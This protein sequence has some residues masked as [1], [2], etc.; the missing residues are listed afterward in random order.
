MSRL[1]LAS[2]L[3]LGSCTAIRPLDAP[4]DGGGR[5]GSP[6]TR[7]A[8]ADGGTDAGADAC[9]ALDLCDG[10]DDDCEPSTADGSGDPLVGVPCDGPDADSCTEG[11]SSCED[12]DVVCSDATGDTLE[13]CGGGDEDCDGETDEPG[14]ANGLTFYPDMDGDGNG[15]AAMGMTFCA[16]PGAPWLILGGD[17]DD[18]DPQVRPGRAE[19]CNAIDDD[20]DGRVDDG[21]GCSFNCDR[22][23][24]AGHTYQICQQNRT[25][26][27]ARMA[28]ESIGYHLVI[29]EDVT[30]N[31]FLATETQGMF[32]F[33]GVWIGLHDEG[34]GF[35]WVDG[36]T[37]AFTAWDTGEPNGT[38]PCA[39]MRSSLAEGRWADL[40]CGVTTGFVCETP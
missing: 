8:A 15:D 2:L 16:F 21:A 22:V 32:A 23:E 36:S 6:S 19:S 10:R 31:D 24:L 39:R 28:C 20:C 25:W 1:V 5:D 14:A 26:D 7:D 4:S 11:T 35:V 40:G 12:G 34:A 17:C 30:E 29:I 18:T 9:A 27:N 37:P 3:A 38:G 13:V 33:Q